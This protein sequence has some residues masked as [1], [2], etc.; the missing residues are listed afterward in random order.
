MIRS[1]INKI[2]HM[3]KPKRVISIENGSSRRSLNTKKMLYLLVDYDNLDVSTV[4]SKLSEITEYLISRIY[5]SLKDN[6]VDAC[7]WVVI[8]L[9]GG[10]YENDTLTLKAQEIITSLSQSP[11]LFEFRSQNDGKK[12]IWRVRIELALGIVAVPGIHLMH[13][14]RKRQKLTGIRVVDPITVGCDPSKCS[15]L[16]I[17]K[18][19]RKNKCPDC[20]TNANQIIWRVEQ[21][22]VDVMLASDIQSLSIIPDTV[23]CVVSSD[24]D[25][26]PALLLASHNAT[27][28]I[29]HMHGV[30]GRH[31]NRIYTKHASTSYIEIQL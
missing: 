12:Q 24:D 27:G 7:E 6:D 26:W 30:P 16:G 11:V 8:R 28:H 25:F 13:T 20:G 19:I 2:I 22:L 5:N 15:I 21:K 29:Y 14:Y 17:K 4:G 1:W 10:W 18:L 23:I 31:I 3:L 9:Y